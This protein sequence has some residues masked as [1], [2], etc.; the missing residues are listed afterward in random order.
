[1][2]LRSG[3]ASR[4]RRSRGS[5][6]DSGAGNTSTSSTHKLTPL[7]T[8]GVKAMVVKQS[9]R[10]ALVAEV[11]A[12]GGA[13][14]FACATGVLLYTVSTDKATGEAPIRGSAACASDELDNAPLTLGGEGASSYTVEGWESRR[15]SWSRTAT[16][17]PFAWMSSKID[18]RAERYPEHHYRAW[19]L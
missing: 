6:A 19:L 8:V 10:A 12:K 3:S 2:P 18:S 13:D 5:T 16:T 14:K 7:E 11:R 15:R 17:T 4:T 1:M 9:E